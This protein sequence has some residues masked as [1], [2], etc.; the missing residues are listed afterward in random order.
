MAPAFQICRNGMARQVVQLGKKYALYIPKSIA[1]ELGLREGDYLLL[2]TH[3]GGILLQPLKPPRL[4][5]KYWATITLEEVEEE[6][7]ELTRKMEGS[8]V[9][10]RSS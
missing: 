8:E 7:E 3:E 4:P 6:G 2:E 10:A 9:D 5:K 1:T